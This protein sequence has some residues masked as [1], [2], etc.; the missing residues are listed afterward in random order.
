[1]PLRY[2]LALDIDP[3][4]ETFQGEVTI[5]VRLLEP[6]DHVWLHADQLTVAA[7]SW[8]GGAL[9]PLALQGEQMRAYGFGKTVPAGTTTLRFTYSG[10]TTGDQEGLFRQR[11]GAWYVYS[12][13]ESVF[14]R[15]ITP[16]FDE[17]RWK[18]PWRVSIVAP[19]RD[20]VLA[21]S[22]EISTTELPR[23]KKRVTFAETPPLPS[24]L[25]AIAVGPFELVDAGTVGRNKVPVRVAVRSGQRKHAGVVAARLPGVVAA[26]ERYLDD[27]LPLTKLDLV[28][29][30]AFFGAMENPGLVTIHEPIV[31]G[32]PQNESFANYFTYIAAHELAHQWFGNSVTPAWWDHLWLSEAFASWLGDKVVREL[33]AYDDTPLRFALARRDA[34]DADRAPD[35]KPLQRHVTTTLDADDGFDAIAYAKG[36]LVL[37]TF[38]SFVGRDVFRDRV[39]A[40]VAAERG[41]VVTSADLVTHLGIPALEK[42]AA[43]AGTPVVDLALRCT[44]K[45]VVV[46]HARGVPVPICI[47]Y[48][49]HRTCALASTSTEIPA[50]DTC[51]AAVLGNVDGGY[52][53]TA[54]TTNGPRGPAPSIL[55]VDPASRIIAGDDLAAA[56]HRGE[57]PAADAIAQLRVFADSRDPYAQLGAI[58]LPRPVDD[59]VDESP[60]PAWTAFLAARF[61][62]RLAYERRPPGAPESE[63]VA[64][65]L[66]LVPADRFAPALTKR[67]SELLDRILA[68]ATA[69][70]PPGLIALASVHG[71]D[72]LFDR[73]VDRAL[74]LRDDD[75]RASWLESLGDL[76]AA[77]IPKAVALVVSGELPFDISWLPVARYLSRPATRLAAWKAVRDAVPEIAKRMSFDDHHDVMT[78]V[79]NLCDTTSRAEVARVFVGEKDLAATLSAIDRCIELRARLGD[80]AGGV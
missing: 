1:M 74:V 20:V 31:L 51:P 37:A 80:V 63:V 32:N 35:A 13:G 18:T 53:H 40:Y 8:A 78:A 59:P 34:I 15:R 26:L 42:L 4:R 21:N 55:D 68:A 66:T 24:Y 27:A 17:P 65:L 77:Q 11:E 79:A 28:T 5:T 10:R 22:A 41:R 61:A 58:G 75:A 14:A 48:D 36:Q 60:P 33:G 50:G 47:S 44:G 23:G 45:P 19:R 57:L 69:E 64:A 52:Y 54:W 49:G 72:K 71:A 43:T 16:C 76:P 25:L 70:M 30:P 2:D 9:I 56:V 7:A 6:T 3:D 39:R 62:D 29:V 46:A 73:V 38:E 67:S 12:Q